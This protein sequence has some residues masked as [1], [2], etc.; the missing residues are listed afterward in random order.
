MER[1]RKKKQKKGHR[2]FLS[3]KVTQDVRDIARDVR[4][5]LKTQEYKL[6]FTELEELHL[7]IK[8]LGNDVSDQ[9]LQIIEQKLPGIFKRYAPFKL[10]V[11]GVQFGFERQTKPRILF[12]QIE[13]TSDVLDIKSRVNKEIKE[14]Y[15]RDVIRRADRKIFTSHVTIARVDR[16]ISKSYVNEVNE[17]LSDLEVPE[18]EFEISAA[19]IIESVLTKN[20]PKYSTISSFPLRGR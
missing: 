18:V 10:K 2:L 11:N 7:T 14:L 9:S 16:D 15:L 17:V 3:F 13:D 5:E 8:F 1:K 20:G 12:L 6:R 4:R 19:H